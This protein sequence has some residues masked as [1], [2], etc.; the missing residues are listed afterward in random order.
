MGGEIIGSPLLSESPSGVHVSSLKLG[1]SQQF[2]LNYMEFLKL[3]KQKAPSDLMPGCSQHSP[4]KVGEF[5]E[6]RGESRER[7]GNPEKKE[8][9]QRRKGS[10]EKEKGNAEKERGIQR[11][12]SPEKEGEVQRRENP[13]KEE[14]IQR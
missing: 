2:Y 10:S 6:L 3:E 7:R 1:C 5:R 13:E 9:V 4:K 12:G 14:G 11:R 8:G